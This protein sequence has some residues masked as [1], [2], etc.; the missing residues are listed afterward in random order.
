MRKKYGK[1]KNIEKIPQELES[2][3]DFEEDLGK[4]DGI[5]SP[6]EMYEALEDNQR[7][8]EEE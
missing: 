8:E 1:R 4:D 6:E 7:M 3:E 2:R 5:L